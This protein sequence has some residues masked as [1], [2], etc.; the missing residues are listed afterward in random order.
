[1]RIHL[2]DFAGHPFQVHLSRALAA[3]GHEV[4]HS[5]ATQYITGHGRLELQAD[6]P[7]TLRIEGVTADSPMVKYSPLGRTRF[8]LRYA[9]AWRRLLAQNPS[10]VVVSCNVPLFTLARMRR[11]FASTDQRWVLWHQDIFSSA[12]GDEAERKLPARAATLTRQAAVGMERKIVRDAHAVVAISEPFRRRYAEWG[13]STGH[14]QVISNW[15][16]I[17]E[18][19]PAPRDNDWSAKLPDSALRLL[20]AGTLG[21]KHNPLL[22]V[23][24]IDRLRAED[25]D[26]NLVIISEGQG[27]DIIAEATL[28]NPRVTV[29]P[30][31]PASV[32]PSALASADVLVGLLEPEASQFS[33]PSKVASYLA[34]G[35]P[36]LLLAPV[37]NPAAAEVIESGG[38][39][40]QPDS[41]G[42][43]ESLAWLGDLAANPARRAEIGHRS[44]MIAEVRYDINTIADAFERI[45]A[46]PGGAQVESNACDSELTNLG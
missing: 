46:G 28:S 34:A 6:D 43:A 24:L 4:L 1:M 36:V 18:I 13:L 14:V 21:R 38:L 22:L 26:A 29:L 12:I 39:V 25:I 27:A 8:E 23:E 44:R 20:Y 30:F 11:Y 17:D 31:Q 15:A 9:T 3:R 40:A 41:L 5:Y 32:L 2:Q 19:T 33:V 42:V 45:L 16:P 7:D 10:D 37:E 35:R